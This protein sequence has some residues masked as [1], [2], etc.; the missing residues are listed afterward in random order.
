M[1]LTAVDRQSGIFSSRVDIVIASGRRMM[2]YLR[3]FKSIAPPVPFTVFLKDPRYNRGDVDIIWAPTHDGLEGSNVITT[4]TSPHT[5]SPTVLKHAA[6]SAAQR[7]ADLPKPLTGIVL[8]GNSK[9]VQWDEKTVGQFIGYLSQLPRD[10]GVVVTTSRRTPD[11]LVNAVRTAL[12]G[13]ACWIWDG[14]EDNPYREIL[15]GSD[16][17]IVTGDSHNMVSESLASGCP[18]HIFRPPGMHHKLQS[19][20]TALEN[21][22]LAFD[23]KGGFEKPATRPFDATGEIA[24]E[25]QKRFEARML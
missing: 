9:T 24:A 11:L 4:L 8:G 3:A 7:F 17:L 5:L 19:F 18:V 14:V 23:L 1:P 20:L 16:R 25:I 6:A 2:P 10:G 13:Y 21:Q 22:Q 12:E 15:A